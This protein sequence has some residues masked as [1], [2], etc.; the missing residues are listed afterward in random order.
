[1]KNRKVLAVQIIS[2]FFVLLFCY[3]AVSKM[4]DFENFQVQIGQSPLL[5]AYAGFVSYAVIAAELVIAGLLLYER[6]RLVG[7]YASFTLMVAFTVYI[8]LIL[9]YSDFVPCSCGGILE[10]MGWTEHLIF[11]VGC[12]VLAAAGALVMEKDQA[13]GL[14]RP[15]LKMVMMFLIG[16][17]GMVVLFLSSE[18]IIK[19]ENNFTRRFL[20]NPVSDKSALILPEEGYYFAGVYRDRIYLGN[21]R[22]PLLL[23]SISKEMSDL[24]TLKIEPE[25]MS[26]NTFRNLQIRVHEN[27]F[28]LSDGTVP[29][30]YRGKLG[31]PIAK[32]ISKG[33]AYF[34]QLAVLDSARFAVRTQSSRTHRYVLALLELQPNPKVTLQEGLL[35]KQ[36]DGVFDVDGILKTNGSHVVYTYHY[37]NQF[38]VMDRDM[39]LLRKLNTIDTTSTANISV[40]NMTGGVRRMNAPPV[41]VNEN[42]T[43]YGSLIFNQS[44]I[45][46]KNE[47]V[48]QWKTSAVID[49]YRTDTQ[50]YLGSFRIKKN[51]GEALHD[52]LITGKYLY[53]L[54]GSTL[55]QYRYTGKF[56]KMIQQG[57]AE[58][59]YQE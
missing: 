15:V 3:A 13:A 30:I 11:N 7:L 6:T 5:S 58:N 44:N 47:S 40:K 18:H 16:S 59:L 54:Q 52:F 27:Y 31:Q 28:Y 20:Q 57:E 21:S 51:A 46:G 43:L 38:L 34:T 32:I 45:R 29:V 12:V 56:K 50:R 39:R 55:R 4:L 48:R 14:R 53:V 22:K 19:R 24:K 49:V 25:K 8:Y 23:T 1:M 36:I 37:R 33:D 42:F 9:N 2:Y 41:K 10:K 26:E 35:E 17:G